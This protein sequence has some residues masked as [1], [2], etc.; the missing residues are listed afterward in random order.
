MGT[1]NERCER[2]RHELLSEIAD[3]SSLIVERLGL[4][5]DL[6]DKAGGE[7]AD[8]IADSL[9]GQVISFP[10]DTKY[11]AQKRNE[12]IAAEF[13]GFNHVELSKRYNVSVR[14]IYSILKNQRSIQK[15]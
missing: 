2:R 8:Y 6:A 13:D 11:R 9:G 5:S 3:A 4:S 12:Q 7:I 14:A 10:R 15:H 1:S